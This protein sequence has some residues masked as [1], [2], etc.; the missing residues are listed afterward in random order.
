MHLQVEYKTG[1]KHHLK[2]VQEWIA[3]TGR[4][5]PL[6]PNGPC[7]HYMQV[8]VAPAG[9][10]ALRARSGSKM[11]IKFYDPGVVNPTDSCFRSDGPFVIIYFGRDVVRTQIMENH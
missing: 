6:G 7:V 10:R 11:V 1:V 5:G 8:L 3:P 4:T 2:V 9:G